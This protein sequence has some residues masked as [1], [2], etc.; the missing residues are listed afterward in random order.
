MQARELVE[1]AAIV[2]A[3]GPVLVRQVPRLSSSGLEEYWT[4][5]KIRLDRWSHALRAYAVGERFPANLPTPWPAL[6]GVAEEILAGEILLRVWTVVLCAH[7]R[8]HRTGEAEPIARSV[9]LGHWETRHRMLTLLLRPGVLDVPMILLLNQFRL[10][11]ERWTDL[12]LGYLAGLH[13]ID[14]FVFD[15]QRADDFA[16]DLN[17]RRQ[18]PGGH[19]AW[20]LVLASLRAAFREG[21]AAESPNADLNARIAAGILAFFPA[22]LFDSTGLFRSLW[23]HRLMNAAQDAQGMIDDLLKESPTVRTA[24]R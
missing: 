13:P 24:R 16:Q 12:L 5:S 15:R 17:Y 14:E 3:Q 21:L 10:R 19:Q 20:P 23:L 7:D 1:L 4:A 11:C 6:R 2:S 9:L 22:E 8:T 18:Q